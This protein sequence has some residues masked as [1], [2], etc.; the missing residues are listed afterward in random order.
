M[1]AGDP[2]YAE[3]VPEQTT[4][5]SFESVDD[6]R[7]FKNQAQVRLFICAFMGMY[8]LPFGFSTHSL[9]LGFAA[10]SLFTFWRSTRMQRV[11]PTSIAVCI[12]LDNA[13]SILGLFATGKTGTFLLFFL[14]HISFGYGIR[15]GFRYLVFSLTLAC[16]GITWLCYESNAWKG[17]IHFFISFLLGMPFIS[18][19]IYY[20]THRI[21]ASELAIRD[22][23]RALRELTAFVL[24][25]LRTPLSAILSSLSIL[26]EASRSPE[27]SMRIRRIIRMISSLGELLS[28]SIG[29]RLSPKDV[30]LVTSD[31]A[32]LARWILVRAE[33]FRDVVEA[34]GGSLLVTLHPSAAY[35]QG[36]SRS[37]IDRIVLNAL[38]NAS[39]YCSRGSISVEHLPT[40]EDSGRQVIRITNRWAP[41]DAVQPHPEGDA[42]SSH[43]HLSGSGL[44]VLSAKSVVERLG[45]SYESV[46]TGE[47]EW[48]T[49][50]DFPCDKLAVKALHE[51]RSPVIFLKS[52]NEGFSQS[53]S[54]D[55]QSEIY[56]WPSGAPIK[57]YSKEV[58]DVP[59]IL[60]VAESFREN[61]LRMLG[62]PASSV[63]VV[64][65]E[66]ASP[67]ASLRVA[68][69]SLTLVG[70]SASPDWKAWVALCEEVHD[71][72]L[73]KAFM[74]L[75]LLQGIS[76][77]VVEDENLTRHMHIN[78]FR[79][80]GAEVYSAASFRQALEFI[81]THQIELLVSDWFVGE[82]VLEDHLEHFVRA[83]GCALQGILVVT[84]HAMT[85]LTSNRVSIPMFSI[86]KPLTRDS[87]NS[88]VEKI[89]GSS[90][91]L[92][93]TA[94]QRETARLVDLETIKE[95][96]ESVGSWA[97]GT[98][99]LLRFLEE[100]DATLPIVFDSA[101]S[102]SSREKTRHKLIGAA[103]VMG[104]D[105]FV[106]C[107]REVDVELNATENAEGGRRHSSTLEAWKYTKAHLLAYVHSLHD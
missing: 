52:N 39:R 45:G 63:L 10:Y 43:S 53:I 35:L 92:Q 46:Q 6:A 9:Y 99:F 95:I 90:V 65:I 22:H 48:T 85:S 56:V 23:E 64:G 27:D 106:N 25:D 93:H 3:R 42:R 14:I 69:T 61:A 55:L 100:I 87:L 58:Q 84:G 32:S 49:V 28:N 76:V 101:S 21:R 2:K 7:S 97:L 33:A 70:S 34:Q 102:S 11:P 15:F 17:D 89:F 86:A 18:L 24:H 19:Y 44:G 31:S 20:L 74:T 26:L 47:C 36:K 96:A 8:Y 88:V 82:E 78:S 5:N 98:K 50:F 62:D 80:L 81:G 73:P 59:W 29:H 103:Q 16:A 60:F 54:C 68:G 4:P 72:I 38:S 13:F 30:H 51:R 57:E 12:T 41:S 67:E 83:E 105:V 40:A 71:A 37:E 104:A 77:L 107:L 66:E 1:T 91:H 75:P 94:T 79:S